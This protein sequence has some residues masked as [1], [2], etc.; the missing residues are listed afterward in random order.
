MTKAGKLSKKSGNPVSKGEGSFN[1]ILGLRISIEYVRLCHSM[2]E[3]VSICEVHFLSLALHQKVLRISAPREGRRAS[4][5]A[6]YNF[7]Q[8]S[9]LPEASLFSELPA[10][11]K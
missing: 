3:R 11:A 6:E 1:S 2:E 10:P 5:R 9:L 4:S 8:R 7:H